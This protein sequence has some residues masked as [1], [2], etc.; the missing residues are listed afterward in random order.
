MSALCFCLRKYTKKANATTMQP[1]TTLPAI[2]ATFTSAPASGEH[3]VGSV[4]EP[5]HAL[6][7]SRTSDP[8][9]VPLQST[10][11]SAAAIASVV[12]VA[13]QVHV[14]ELVAVEY[15]PMAHEC[16]QRAPSY[17]TQPSALR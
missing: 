2:S 16:R 12:A 5:P 4:I 17:A 1:P 14:I 3:F 7:A 13:L 10:I 15:A 9:Y 8:P 11:N 6:Q